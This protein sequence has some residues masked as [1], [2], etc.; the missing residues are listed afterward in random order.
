MGSPP[1]TAQALHPDKCAAGGGTEE[2]AAATERFSRLQEAYEVLSDPGKRDVYDVYG[3]EGLRAGLEVGHPLRTAG[4]V[5]REFERYKRER[6]MEREDV[7][8]AYRGSYVF[9]FAAAPMVAADRRPA[10]SQPLQLL[11]VAMSSSASVAVG[12]ADVFTVGGNAASR[13][14]RGG[15]NLMVGWRRQLTALSVLDVGLV[16]GPSSAITLTSTQRL[17]KYTNGSLALTLQSDEYAG[18]ALSHSR[19]LTA[20]VQGELSYTVGPSSGV[21][22]TFSHRAQRSAA[23]ADLKLGEGIVALAGSVTR[24]VGEKHHVRAAAKLGLTAMEVEAGGGRRLAEGTTTYL[25]AGLGVQGVFLKVR[26]VHKGHR[27][28][29]PILLAP[30]LDWRITVGAMLLPP[31]VIFVGERC[32]IRP[33][34]RYHRRT[35]AL[36]AQ[37]E[38]KAEIEEARAAAAKDRALFQSVVRRRLKEVYRT[39]GLVVVEARYGVLG[40]GE[41]GDEEQALGG[42]GGTGDVGELWIDVVDALQ[43]QVR[44]NVLT[45]HAGVPKSGLFGFCD[46][47]PEVDKSLKLEY[48]CQGVAYQCTVGDLE[49]VKAP[50]E[51]HRVLDAD[52]AVAVLARHAARRETFLAAAGAQAAAP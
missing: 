43:F 30:V 32:V 51:L 40:E 49:G 50:N 46:I 27:F 48:V 3:A 14:G 52:L 25:G 33:L 7:G 10:Q 20:T 39:G 44:E 35:K 12:E 23:V 26:V 15:G 17:S 4:E 22:L 24:F 34:V 19:Q 47:V 11:S 41:G 36:R 21:G 31:L 1:R 38:K 29:F 6:E 13:Q 5:R 28:Q 9:G 8:V 16:L 2:R 42:G 18:L 45:L 37:E